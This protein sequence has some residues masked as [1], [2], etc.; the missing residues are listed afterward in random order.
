[1]AVLSISRIPDDHPRK[2]AIEQT[3]HEV[4]GA[5]KGDWWV[6][7]V[8]SAGTWTLSIRRADDHLRR[9]LVL[10]E[11]QQTPEDVS[12][13]LALALKDVA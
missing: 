13:E 5:F 3:I 8:P 4:L 9:T 11:G 10:N 2:D 12:A 1:M 6:R 7:V